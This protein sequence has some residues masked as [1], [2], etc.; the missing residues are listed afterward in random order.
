MRK[1]VKDNLGLFI[2]LFFIIADMFF[3]I[4][5]FEKNAGIAEKIFFVVLLIVLLWYFSPYLIDLMTDIM[6]PKVLK[7]RKIYLDAEGG[8]EIVGQVDS[9]S[10]YLSK[11][12]ASIVD[13]EDAEFRILLKPNPVT[14]SAL[15]CTVVDQKGYKQTF[16]G[17]LNHWPKPAALKIVTFIK[18]RTSR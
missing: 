4:L 1:L 7:G 5:A 15:Y 2:G 11:K 3:I 18:N 8:Y 13:E 10:L 14:T 12:G 16:R 6:I 9:L 17:F